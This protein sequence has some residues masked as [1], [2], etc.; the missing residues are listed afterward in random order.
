MGVLL[1]GPL[2]YDDHGLVLDLLGV[3][4]SHGHLRRLL[5]HGISI[6]RISVR[7]RLLGGVRGAR[8]ARRRVLV[9]VAHG[10]AVNGVQRPLDH[11][12]HS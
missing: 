9:R 8:A 3:D 2:R 6:R 7:R 11:C 10:G 5:L 12:D 4:I 1:T